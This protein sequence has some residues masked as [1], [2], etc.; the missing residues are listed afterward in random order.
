MIVTVNGEATE[1]PEGS[2]VAAIVKRMDLPGIRRGIAVAVDAEVVPRAEW[3]ERVVGEGARVEVVS[4]V[5]GG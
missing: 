5:Q 1:L 2:T 4:A 3:D